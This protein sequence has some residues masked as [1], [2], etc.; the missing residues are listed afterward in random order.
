MYQLLGQQPV[1]KTN[2]RNKPNKNYKNIKFQT[3][4]LSYYIDQN[5]KPHLA[6]TP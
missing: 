4:L 2:V 3:Y 5:V 1:A 6:I